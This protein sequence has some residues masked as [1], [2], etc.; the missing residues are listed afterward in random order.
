MPNSPSCYY[1]QQRFCPR[2]IF[3]CRESTIINH[4]TIIRW[5][6]N[7]LHHSEGVSLIKW[8]SRLIN[9]QLWYQLGGHILWGW[10]VLPQDVEY[11]LNQWPTFGMFLSYTEYMCPGIKGKK[12]KWPFSLL[13]LIIHSH[14]FCFLSTAFSSDGLDVL[15]FSNSKFKYTCLSKKSNAFSGISRHG[16]WQGEKAWEA[17]ICFIVLSTAYWRMKKATHTINSLFLLVAVRI[18]VLLLWQLSYWK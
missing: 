10:N 18:V 5:S 7:V 17:R 16:M 11:A 13:Y 4:A 2:D 14:N 15:D 3:H 1:I 6:W 12:W 9:I 8:W